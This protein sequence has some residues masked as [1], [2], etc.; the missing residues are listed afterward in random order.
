MA[1][2]YT[3]A[4]KQAVWGSEEEKAIGRRMLGFKLFHTAIAAGVLGWPMMNVAALMF[5][6]LGGDD[7]KKDMEQWLR[8]AIGDEDLSALL[9]HGP[10]A[11]LGLDMSPK[12]GEDKVY[13]IDPYHT[14]DFSTGK[15]AMQTV[16]GLVA[17]PAG[18][19][20]SRFIDGVSLMKDG[21]M[22]KG[23]EK[24]VPKGLES[25]MQSFRLANEGFT[26]RNGDLLVR[27]EDIGGFTLAL[28][29]LG[30]PTSE[31]KDLSR[32]RGLQYEVNK[33]FT[34]RQKEIEHE[35][36][37][38]VKEG[39][40]DAASKARGDWRALQDNKM[41]WR[42]LFNNSKDA[43]KKQPLST[44]LKYPSTVAKRTTK[45]QRALPQE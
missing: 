7:D 25:A 33:F 13:S 3:K 39:D 40:S 44:L 18:G 32:V 10:S 34:D 22:Y 14:W 11:M 6:A 45:E 20:A 41:E 1:A 19:L 26:L 4:F 8:D 35:Y 17:G 23:V 27:P 30:L 16:G 2:L 21:Q 31:L 5:S 28:N 38:A 29:A 15:G 37:A 43:L 9:L 24:M 12:L 42:P 36:A